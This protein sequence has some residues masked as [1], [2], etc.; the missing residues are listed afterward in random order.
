[1]VM[2][3]TVHD[4]NTMTDWNINI[5]RC[6]K[7]LELQNFYSLTE[8]GFDEIS[9]KKQ[10]RNAVDFIADGRVKLI[11]EYIK[12]CQMYS[13]GW[14]SSYS[15]VWDLY[16]KSKCLFMPPGITT[17]L[18]IASLIIAIGFYNL[19]HCIADRS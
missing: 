14:N 10:G 15:L 1:M 6:W 7:I 2:F 3:L 17:S 11:A 5:N 19:T 4:K 16:D 8:N 13:S 9:W 12:T 18:Y